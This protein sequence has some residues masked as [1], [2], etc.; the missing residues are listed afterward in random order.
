MVGLS[1]APSAGSHLLAAHA[2]LAAAED[3]GLDVSDLDGLLV[4]RSGGALESDLGL[5]LQ[6]T[7]ALPNLRLL[8]VGYVEGASSIALIQ[9][10]ALAVSTGM[11]RA[12]ACVFADAPLADGQSA[13]EAFG[14]RKSLHGVESLRYAAGLFGGASLYALAARRYM[15]VYGATAEHFGAV[16][17]S[18]R[19]WASM[20]PLAVFRTPLSMEAYL[21]SRWIVEPLRLYDCAMPVNGAIAVIV[22]TAARAADLSKPPVH[23]LGM[24][25]GHPGTLDQA[26]SEREL[27]SGG[28]LA[29]QTALRMAGIELGDIDV[30]QFYDAFT[31][32]TIASLEAYGFCGPGEGKDFV[33]SGAIAP[34]GSL[35]VNTGGDICPVTTF[36][37]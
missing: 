3:A 31:Y 22:T 12:V 5:G 36:K 28:G 34:G 10:A 2:V 11:A 21:D 25:Q 32:G 19:A 4:C 9:F 26:G 6:R 15:H 20:N 1:R 23:I 30:C 13:R 17:I 37:A 7:L 29:K 24:G 14:R 35:P 27:G 33:A 16:A 18:A 8:Q